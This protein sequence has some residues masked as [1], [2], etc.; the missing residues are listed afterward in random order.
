MSDVSEGR[1][2]SCMGGEVSGESARQLR[3]VKWLVVVGEDSRGVDEIV[4]V[5]S[6]L[7]HSDDIDAISWS[8]G[9][10]KG[11]R[12]IWT[13]RWRREGGDRLELG[14]GLG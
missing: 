4:K 3:M 11:R 12:S 2:G 9:A 5:K 10:A 1:S 8:V 7:H 13:R 6:M 14:L